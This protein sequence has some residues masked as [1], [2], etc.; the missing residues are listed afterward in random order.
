MVCRTTRFRISSRVLTNLIVNTGGLEVWKRATPAAIRSLI[1][2]QYD[3]FPLICGD[4]AFRLKHMAVRF[5][6]IHRGCTREMRQWA[7]LLRRKYVVLAIATWELCL[8]E[9]H[10]ATRFEVPMLLDKNTPFEWYHEHVD[11]LSGMRNRIG[12]IR[13]L[14]SRKP[15]AD[16]QLRQS[17]VLEPHQQGEVETEEAGE[18]AREACG[19]RGPP[20]S[21]AGQFGRD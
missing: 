17:Y 10:V 16:R 20:A 14:S 12:S 18:A 4:N 2:Q 7:L 13:M 19:C 6:T 3:E 1:E 11:K 5:E 15:Q 9:G 21:S 8:S